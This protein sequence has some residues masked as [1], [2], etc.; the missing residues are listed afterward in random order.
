M[1]KLPSLLLP[2]FSLIGVALFL[3]SC[4][5][6]DF[7]PYAGAQEHWPTA[8]GAFV[9]TQFAVPAYYGLPSRPYIVLGYLD[10]T[11]APIRRREVVE[12]SARRA[13]E[14]G[15]DAIIVMS[16]G[17]QYAGTYST[18]GAFTSGNYTGSY[19]YGNIYG[20]GYATT[21]SWGTSIPLFLGKASVL[22][23][24]FA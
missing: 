19:G 2:N 16:S 3:S 10:A 21:N 20:T 13:K 6:A 23:I 5:T 11:T 14:I 24:K 9:A 8:R 1:K 7:T 15:G 12:F 4:A 18:G 17:A 22:I